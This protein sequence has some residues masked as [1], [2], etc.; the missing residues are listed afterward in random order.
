MYRDTLN[1]Q[2]L[3][4]LTD[5]QKGLLW[6]YY[7][8]LKTPSTSI[9]D[10]V[11]QIAQIWSKAEEDTVLCKWLELIDYFYTDISKTDEE[12]DNN[13]RA[14]LS[15][16]LERLLEER[17]NPIPTGKESGFIQAGEEFWVFVCPNHSGYVRIPIQGKASMTIEALS[18]KVCGQC[19]T[20][21]SEHQI[22]P[23]EDFT[24]K[25]S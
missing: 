5:E 7:R 20:K 8:L 18:Q 6:Q 1:G 10:E 25:Q 22:M 13:Q 12:A 23:V 11:E 3:E 16:H 24:R 21:L 19:K 17:T 14:Y 4:H 15:E 2:F 9:D